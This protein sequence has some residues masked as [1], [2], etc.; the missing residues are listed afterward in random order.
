[1]VAENRIEYLGQDRNNLLGKLLQV[2]VL[3]TLL[4]TNPA[5]LETFNGSVNIVK[6]D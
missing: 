3:D 1:M 2:P 5:H 6:V 4:A